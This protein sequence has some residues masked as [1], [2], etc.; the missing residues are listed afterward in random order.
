MRKSKRKS[1][2]E[3]I[4]ENKM[5]ILQDREAIISIEDRL[6]ERLEKRMLK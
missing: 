3:L 4:L 1:L 5:K 2:Q 6:E